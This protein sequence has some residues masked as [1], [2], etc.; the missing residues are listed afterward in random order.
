MV[1]PSPR[2]G[3]GPAGALRG[4][5]L[6][7]CLARRNLS[8][9]SQPRPRR[10]WGHEGELGLHDC[11][12]T[13]YTWSLLHGDDPFDP[14]SYVSLCKSCHIRY[15]WRWRTRPSTILALI[16]SSGIAQLRDVCNHVGVD[17]AAAGVLL[18]LLIVLSAWF[19]LRKKGNVA[20]KFAAFWVTVIV[21]W[22]FVAAHSITSGVDIAT[23]G[24]KGAAADA[25]GFS[26]F[27]ADAIGTDPPTSPNPSTSPVNA[28]QA[29]VS[30]CSWRSRTSQ[31]RPLPSQ[32]PAL[33]R[34]VCRNLNR[35]R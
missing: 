27:A 21:L 16:V 14:L 13:D 8:S 25:A 19:S 29:S 1:I 18:I 33:H 17:S 15:D 4:P 35:T 2:A 5:W 30:A 10:S 7:G 20:P 34:T 11:R 23:L 3:G 12:S 28:L 31:S 6:A 22:L 26:D 24:A 32:K 9:D